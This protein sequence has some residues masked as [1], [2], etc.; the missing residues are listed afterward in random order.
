[1]LEL[2]ILLISSVAN[3]LLGLLVYI[4][5]PRAI[6]NRLFLMLAITIVAWSGVNFASV[7]PV[8]LSQL[9][10]IRLVLFTGGFLNLSVF[11]TFL[12]FPAAKMPSKSWRKIKPAILATLIVMPLTLTPLVFKEL[13]YSGNGAQP[14]PNPGIALFLAQTVILLGASLYILYKKYRTSTGVLRNQ[15]RLILLGVG[16]TFALIIVNN[17]LLVVIFNVTFFVPAGPLFTLLFTG[18]LAYAIIKHHLFDIRRVAARGLAY[19]LSITFMSTVYVGAVFGLSTLLLGN[20]QSRTHSEVIYTSLALV[21]AL[22]FQAIKRFFDKLS[23]RVFYKD[24]YNPENFLDE[25]NRVL[26]ARVELEPLLQEATNV[27]MQNLKV[28]YCTFII[29]KT[30]YFPV[31]TIGSKGKRFNEET[32]ASLREQLSVIREKV[33]ATDYIDAEHIRLKN[34]LYRNNVAVVARLIPSIEYGLEG[35]G[36]LVLGPKKNGDPYTDQDIQLLEIISNELVIAVQNSLRFEEIEAFS[37]TLQDKVDTATRQL[38]RTNEKLQALDETKDEFI[39]MASHQLRTPLTSVKGYVSMVLEGDA[40]E[41]NP[42]QRKLLE[43]SFASS[44]RMVYLIADLLNLSRLRTG[45]FIIEAK[46]TNLADVI[47]SEV[48]QL[49]ASAAGRNLTLTYEKPA[50]FPTLMIDETKIRQVIMNFADN[51]IYYTPTGGKI[52]IRLKETSDSVEFTVND[53]GI[54]IP[55]DEQHHLFNKF[56]RAK[57]AQ[58]ARPDGTG[59]G[60]FMAKKVIIA[61]GGAIIFK[62]KEGKGSTFGFAFSKQKL[63]VPDHLQPKAT[64]A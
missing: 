37:S 62:S 36:E 21:L 22:S 25:L 53:N 47:E 11:L 19:I 14:V 46:P 50:K 34:L 8:F 40:G 42:T 57:N 43:Q 64:N 3:I 45:K 1:M 15:L 30:A 23:N 10:L 18:A 56:Y 7:H 13:K 16:S 17:L 2:S 55:A 63:R 28:D 12:A 61:Q 24:A 29:R 49:T 6:T 59:L 31:R 38:K 26:V 32:I 5:N 4:K 9:T 27:I 54:G 60:L 48:D 39:S 35:T 58:K 51:A 52:D 44:Q 41:L 33:I 20:D